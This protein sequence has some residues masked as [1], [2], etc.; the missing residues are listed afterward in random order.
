MRLVIR[1]GSLLTAA[2]SSLQPSLAQ[3][4]IEVLVYPLY[5]A[6]SALPFT[7]QDL[8]VSELGF[9]PSLQ[10]AS[11]ILAGTPSVT[12][13]SDSG[14]YQGY[15]Y[16]RIRGIDQSRI[17]MTLDG[18]PLNEPEDQ[19]VYFSNYPG[20]FA[21][22]SQVQI[23]RGVGMSQNGTASFGGSVQLH[24]AE[25]GQEQQ[26][27]LSTELG[28]FGTRAGTFEL[29]SGEMGN[30]T[31]YIHGAGVSSDG[32]KRNSGNTSY[33]LF[34]KG[35][36]KDDHGQWKALAFTGRQK[37]ELAWLGV[38]DEDLNRDRRF[39]ENDQEHDVFRQTL[40][41]VGREERVGKNSQLELTAYHN[42]LEGNYDFNLNN[43]LQIDEPGEILNYALKSK[44]TGIFASLGQQ[45]GDLSLTSGLHIN[46][47][48]RSHIGTEKT[49]D[50]FLYRNT[51]HKDSVSLFAKAAYQLGRFSLYSDA[52]LRHTR[53][54]YEGSIHL[55]S[56]D[57]TFF[58]P[59][60]G[61]AYSSNE[62]WSVYYSV[63]KTGREPTRTDI[64]G[65]NDNLEADSTGRA[66]IFVTDDESVIDHEAGFRLTLENL[67]WKANIF[68]MY[69]ADEITLNGGIGPNGLLLNENVEQSTRYGLETEFTW[70]ISPG[71]TFDIDL[72][73]MN[74]EIKHQG[75]SF[76]PVLSPEILTNSHL[77]FQHH[78]LTLR[79]SARYQSESYLDLA[80]DHLI[81]GFSVVDFYAAYT[82][83]NF[84][85]ELHVNNILNRKYLSSGTIDIYGQ[86]GYFVGA[87]RNALISLS[88]AW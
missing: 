2:L 59:R 83:D 76:H 72:T 15:S 16:F 8:D 18:I 24:S 73:R 14:S 79:T 25:P 1:S 56:L 50:S 68:R 35:Q 5:S 40:V 22:L 19:G 11:F 36:H 47:Y 87:P 45:L 75:E 86:P 10:E 74:A 88:M 13:H 28:S 55:K 17:N 57:W 54:E 41:S 52:Q 58:N 42:R 29:S 39:N 43:F 63:G 23:Q 66:A 34:L 51:G 31:F 44:F 20:L 32:Y 46:A 37:N 62:N 85:L 4:V 12:T 81:E 70:Q 69:F 38:G 53:F 80:N 65:G 48:E 30:N 26:T 3:P 61:I 67:D 78:N 9:S 7:Y 27:T 64:F 6:D 84:Q 71:L 77:T 60:A 49:T 21:S 82:V 33:S